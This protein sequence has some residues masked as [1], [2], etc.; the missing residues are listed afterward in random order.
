MADKSK[1][2]KNATDQ[3]LDE[4]IRRLRKENEV[5]GII[6]DIKRKSTEGY[7]PYDYNQG[8]STE[9]S[10]E[11]LYHFGIPGMHWGHRNRRGNPTKR[12][13]QTTQVHDDV[14]DDHIKKEILK[15]KKLNTMSNSEIKSLN[16]R[17]QL[18]RQYRDLTKTEISPGKRFV[19]EILTN[20]AKETAKTYTTKYMN[21]AV[22]EL[23]KKASK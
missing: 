2:I 20:A 12:T 23:I 18:E 6:A 4:L 11:S 21:K 17:L 16:E 14:S 19:S 5:Q 1:T 8:V 13:Q 7:T 9:K 3:E 22:E 10:I 15:T